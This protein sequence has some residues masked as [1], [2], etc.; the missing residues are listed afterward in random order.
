MTAFVVMVAAFGVAFAVTWLLGFEQ[1]D[2]E[3][4]EEITG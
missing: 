2:Q 3:M 4:A 1:P